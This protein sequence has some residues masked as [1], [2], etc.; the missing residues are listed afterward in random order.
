MT[1]KESAHR[2]RSKK[3][4]ANEKYKSD[5]AF[6]K[7]SI[8]AV[9]RRKAAKYVDHILLIAKFRSRGCRKCSE[10]DPDCLCAHHRNPATKLFSIGSF[11]VVKPTLDDFKKELKKCT[12]LCFNCHIKLHARKRRREKRNAR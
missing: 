1:R 4:W 6:R 8:D 12:C 2:K 3:A 5:P 11:A 9:L 10:D 7:K